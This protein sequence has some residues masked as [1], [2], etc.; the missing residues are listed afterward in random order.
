MSKKSSQADYSVWFGPEPEAVEQVSPV[1]EW[2]RAIAILTLIAG[3]MVAA[4]ALLQGPNVAAVVAGVAVAGSAFPIFAM[5]RGLLLL[6]RIA[7]SSSETA[8]HM[9][10]LVGRATAN[11]GPRQSAQSQPATNAPEKREPRFEGR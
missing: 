2:L 11:A 5:A 8:A 6:E 4:F 1:I 9:G 10:R 3:I 7:K